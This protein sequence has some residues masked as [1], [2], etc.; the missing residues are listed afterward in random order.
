MIAAARA[1]LSFAALLPVI[2]VCLFP[3][4]EAAALRDIHFAS[5]DGLDVA[6][7]CLIEKIRCGE[8]IAVI[9]DS[10]RG[11]FLPRSFVEKLRGFAGTIEQAV[12]GMYVQMNELG[13]THEFDSKALAGELRYA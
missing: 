2:S 3:T 1:W 13:L 12:I 6:L 5:D 8:Q 4:I 11:H 7:A 10:H 9:R